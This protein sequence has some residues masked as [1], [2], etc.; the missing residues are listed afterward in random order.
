VST[1]SYVA[2]SADGRRIKDV[3]EASSASGLEHELMR[4][5]LK[6]LKIREKKSF[7]QIEITK[8][9]VPRQEVMHFARQ[10]SA[11]V[12]SGITLTDAIRVVFESTENARFRDILA[13][14]GEDLHTG[15][16]FSDAVARH[17]EVFPP[18]FVGIVRS[19]ELTGQLDVVLD[20]LAEYM[21]RDLDAR[22]K[23]K[24][25]LTYPL[26]IAGMAV[27]TVLVMLIF[28]L[29]RFVTFFED[30]D[31]ELPL[32]TR[33]LLGV[34]DFTQ[35]WGWLIAIVIALL[36]IGYLI[37]MRSDG[38]R[39][40]R[41]KVL[42][43]T[44]L[45][46]DIIRFSVIERFCRIVGSMMRAG[47]PLPEAMIAAIEGSNNKVF[48]RALLQARE[49]MVQGEGMTAPLAATGLFPIAAVQMIRVGEETG[50]V[51]RQVEG[52]AAYYGREVEYKLKKLTT[53][54]EPAIII[55]MGGV[56]GFVAV[57]LISA[58]YGIFQ[59]E[60]L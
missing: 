34:S 12:R 8:Q 41:D 37:A 49:S 35:S 31:T 38:G 46:G 57:A 55:A 45:I 50:T 59:N 26:V 47:V 44:P 21:E 48:E 13:D 32:A 58:M 20:Q 52:A 51:D 9:K 60:N 29:P 7:S 25:A 39:Y 27:V 22:Q 10:L 53:I 24:A 56:V 5:D 54:F 28:V 30:L 43:K 2:V 33:L 1:Y 3:A 6:V 17:R 42:L 40:A 4:Q 15:L 18:Y 11:F 23:V 19:A 36:V 14:I 16:P